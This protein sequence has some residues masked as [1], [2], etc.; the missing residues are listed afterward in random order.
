MR[1]LIDQ[2]RAGH[3]PEVEPPRN[4]AQLAQ[5]DLAAVG[6][7]HD[8]RVA[9]GEAVLGLAAGC[10]RVT[11]LD[12]AMPGRILGAVPPGLPPADGEV[13]VCG[14]ERIIP[15]LALQ[16]L[17]QRWLRNGGGHR[18]AGAPPPARRLPSARAL[19]M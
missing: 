11:E 12:V 5:P 19:Q 15:R 3:Q 8:A 9:G 7:Y 6:E 2:E 4:D 14:I 17:R 18:L 1:A 13:I 16:V 10:E